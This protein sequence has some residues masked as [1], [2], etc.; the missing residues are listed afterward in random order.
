[1]ALKALATGEFAR[2]AF[3]ICYTTDPVT[4]EI[5]GMCSWTGDP[6]RPRPD[7]VL[8]GLTTRSPARLSHILLGQVRPAIKLPKPDQDA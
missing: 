2:D 3:P 8:L 7:T 6:P 4:R 5:V 1:M